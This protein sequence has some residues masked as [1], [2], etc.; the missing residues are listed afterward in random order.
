MSSA[1]R[2]I[3]TPEAFGVHTT[4]P[5]TEANKAPT[6]PATSQYERQH[7]LSTS[8][9]QLLQRN[10]QRQNELVN[11]DGNTNTATMRQ[12]I[13]VLLT[14]IPSTGLMRA[15]DVTTQ[16]QRHDG[17]SN[18]SK[19]KQSVQSGVHQQAEVLP[20]VPQASATSEGIDDPLQGA[21]IDL[22]TDIHADEQRSNGGMR[23]GRKR[24]SR[25]DSDSE[26]DDGSSRQ[27]DHDQSLEA[28]DDKS[29]SESTTSRQ[30]PCQNNMT[31]ARAATSTSGN[32]KKAKAVSTKS[33]KKTKAKGTRRTTPN[34]ER[35]TRKPM[36]EGRTRASRKKV[37]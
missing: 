23:G 36:E 35:S 3:S 12:Q 28:E 32:T 37:N 4:A 11:T 29:N 31:T 25:A 21:I 2:P 24:K 14:R 26:Q 19:D 16:Q 10:Q 6:V 30:S 1:A 8:T 27:S 17:A 7:R 15:V 34:V 22:D 18:A 5:T 20:S 13:S 9:S 33:T